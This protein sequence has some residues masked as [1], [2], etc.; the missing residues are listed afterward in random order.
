LC[1]KHK[2]V[3]LLEVSARKSDFTR[4]WKQEEAAASGM[5]L[6]P[7]RRWYTNGDNKYLGTD[8]ITLFEQVAK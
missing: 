3:E 7:I 4:S 8:T 1:T 2:H 6:P 5:R